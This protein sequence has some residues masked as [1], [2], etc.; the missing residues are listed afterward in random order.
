M[1]A[2]VET[3]TREM[4]EARDEAERASGAKGEFLAT[5]SHEIRTPMN[6]ILGYS[7]LLRRDPTLGKSHHDKLDAI[8]SSGDHLL[9]LINNVLDMSRIDAGKTSLVIAPFNLHALLNELRD[10]FAELIA[11]KRLTLAFDGVYA[12]PRVVNADAGRVRQVLINLVSNALKFTERGGITIRAFCETGTQG[13]R[14][15]IAVKDSGAGIGREHLDRVFEVFEQSAVGVGAGGA[16]LGLPIARELARLMGGDL[17]VS[18]VEGSGSTF[19]FSFDAGIADAMIAPRA[20]HVVR[21]KPGQRR[22]KVL[23]VDDQPDNL[24]IADELLRSVGFETALATRGEEALA[25]HEEWHPDLIL[26]DVRMPGMGGIE[27]IR[28][29]RTSGS[30]TLAV[31]FTASGL[32]AMASEA[33]AAGADDVV[34]K[35]CKDA[36]L[37]E[38]IGRLLNLEYE[39]ENAPA[40]VLPGSVAPAASAAPLQRLARSVPPAL[41]DELLTV[42]VQARTAQLEQLAG[43]VARHDPAAADHIR[44]LAREFR[45]DE[46]IGALRAIPDA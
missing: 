27:A 44:T 40:G 22:P 33:R 13:H 29:L 1:E 46:L 14:V 25:V 45:L 10:M 9:T 21:I 41:L 35:P 12:L 32:D 7:Q 36:Q 20:D 19:T 26:M 5:M 28:R 23:I 6:A 15:T 43:D 34:L 4:R 31:A 38:V 17:T 37:L 18:S 11:A 3:R 8:L 42:A 30:R 16:G 24:T 2:L 39:Y